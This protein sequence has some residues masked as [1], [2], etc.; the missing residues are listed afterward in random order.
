M[1]IRDRYYPTT[2]LQRPPPWYPQDFYDSAYVPPTE[3]PVPEYLEQ[4]ILE[5]ELYPFQ[6]RAV[7][8]MLEREGAVIQRKG[9]SREEHDGLEKREQDSDDSTVDGIP[10]YNIPPSF[11]R[12]VDA[13][14]GESYVSHLHAMIGTR[15][16]LE[17]LAE[18][19]G[20]ILAEEMG[21]GKT[22]ELISLICL[23]KRKS[24]DP[25]SG[26]R[27][28][29]ATLIVTPLTI[30]QQWKDE[31]AKHA[32]HLSCMHY[33]GVNS[34]SK[35]KQTEADVVEA[36]ANND[37]VLTTYTV[38]AREIHFAVDPPERNLRRRESQH[39]RKR[40]PLVQVHWWRV[41]L[42]EAQ[43]VES[44]VSAAAG[45][46][47]LLE[48]ENAWAV[49]GTPVRKD[50]LD[51]RG[52][53]IF[54]KYRP[55]DNTGRSWNRLVDHWRDDW[56][57]L[58]NRISLRHT[59]DKIRHELRLP[60]QRRMVITVPFTAIEEQNYKSLFSDMAAECGCALDGSPLYDQWNPDLYTERMRSWLV[61][62]RQTA[63]I[64]K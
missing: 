16:G 63:C 4:R 60:P 7:H 33:E 6:K 44:G 17:Y 13:D 22:C 3:K 62:L 53:L 48:R 35:S 49:S 5:T 36:F 55:F 45:V 56:K 40:S 29:G 61:R 21:L 18:P 59:K 57:L 14:S 12:T 1:C 34:L 10:A 39:A 52:L 15:A 20:G 42:D 26:L 51:L 47:A 64:L 19:K 2:P 11:S 37:V 54:L 24:T 50:V 30:L 38:L 58:F 43:M 9:A 31:L 28:T 25:T 32:P 23:H 46:A 8:W 41:C 27:A